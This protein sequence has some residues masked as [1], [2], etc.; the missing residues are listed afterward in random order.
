MKLAFAGYEVSGDPSPQ[1]NTLLSWAIEL[2]PVVILAANV[3]APPKHTLSTC[4]WSGL[5]VGGQKILN[6]T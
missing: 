2:L 1:F 3:L 6:W 5:I 4:V